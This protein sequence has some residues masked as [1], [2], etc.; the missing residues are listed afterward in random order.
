MTDDQ[1][2]ETLALVRDLATG[3]GLPVTSGPVAEARFADLLKTVET[4]Q[5]GAA[6][7][8]RSGL[9]GRLQQLADE[10]RAT[11]AVQ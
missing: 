1:T 8:L 3:F 11:G 2:A 4:L 7:R 6:A 9:S 5:P 10:A